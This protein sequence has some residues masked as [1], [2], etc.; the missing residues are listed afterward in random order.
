MKN[1]SINSLV[2]MVKSGFEQ[3]LYTNGDNNLLGYLDSTLEHVITARTMLEEEETVYSLVALNR[4]TAT[5]EKMKVYAQQPETPMDEVT[6]EFVVAMVGWLMKH[7]N[8][9][10]AQHGTGTK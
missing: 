8:T 2:I 1:T 4:A 9:V 7:T 6:R 10:K 5:L 3:F